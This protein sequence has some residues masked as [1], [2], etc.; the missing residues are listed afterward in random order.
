MK[1]GHILATCST[2]EEKL[3]TL[4]SVAEFHR[5]VMNYLKMQKLKSENK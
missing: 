2:E 5:I 3:Q 1:L 4:N